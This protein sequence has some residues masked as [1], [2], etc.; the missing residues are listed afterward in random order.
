M[1]NNM[2]FC[3]RK[4][5][6]TIFII[7]GVVVAVI[8]GGAVMLNSNTLLEKTYDPEVTALRQNILDCFT[9]EYKFVLNKNGF[10]GGYSEIPH[11]STYATYDVGFS[12]IP[13][14][15]DKG[16][17][18]LPTIDMLEHELGKGAALSLGSCITTFDAEDEGVSLSYNDIDVTATIFPENIQFVADVDM[19]AT[20]ENR[21]V[22]VAFN[23]ADIFIESQLTAMHEVAEIVV[24][25]A[26]NDP[27]EWIDITELYFAV[28]ERNLDV[29]I[30]DIAEESE[31]Y[32]FTVESRE[33]IYY[34]LRLNFLMRYKLED[35]GFPT[36]G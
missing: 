19:T 7:V 31:S 18:L 2:T 34:P 22:V 13:Y 17:P 3:N 14:Y 27:L 29:A 23:D 15:Y 8:I 35:L 20:Y 28:E 33:D 25:Q 24:L 1:H 21:T 4:G 16:E 26:V 30:L 12:F 9:E 11:V 5:Q 6:V 10:S 32:L 36:T